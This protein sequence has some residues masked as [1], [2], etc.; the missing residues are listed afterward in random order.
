MWEGG[1]PPRGREDVDLAVCSPTD[2]SV[3][4]ESRSRAHILSYKKGGGG[5]Y[6]CPFN[7]SEQVPKKLNG[8]TVVWVRTTGK[9]GEELNGHP[10]TLFPFS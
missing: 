6:G 1:D 2:R 9:E 3:P 7:S 8:V 10:L 5:E 4:W